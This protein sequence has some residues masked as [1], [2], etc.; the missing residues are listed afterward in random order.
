[1]ALS[2]KEILNQLGAILSGP[3]SNRAWCSHDD[4]G[5]LSSNALQELFHYNFAASL[6]V[7]T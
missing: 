1:V 2:Y 7:P 3:S 5:C 4:K 6:D